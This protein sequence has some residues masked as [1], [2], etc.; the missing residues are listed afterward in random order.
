MFWW[1]TQAGDGLMVA[2]TNTTAGNLALHVGDHPGQ[3]LL[4]RAALE[5]RMQVPAGSL[6]F[7]NQV[8]SADVATVDTADGLGPGSPS[9][10]PTADALVSA[11]G[12][13]PLAVMVADCVPVLLA[14]R[15]PG[16]V[17]TAAAHAGRRGLLDGVLA[18]T[19][20]TMRS[21]GATGLRAWIGPAVCGAC[22]EVP[23]AMLADAKARLPVL[24][25]RTRWDT[26][27]LDLPAG[28]EAELTALDVQVIRLPGCTLESDDL[29]S[30]RR[31]N[32]AGRFAGVIWRR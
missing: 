7:M 9:A 6:R 11:D 23:E 21:A 3:V 22:Y 14:G 12:S 28:A 5:K 1:Q 31:S 4:R 8:H 27:A 30:H 15:G 32:A 18:N 17:V 25:S 19:V 29:Y 2:F 10:V 20:A 16:G 24:A 13:S 26:P